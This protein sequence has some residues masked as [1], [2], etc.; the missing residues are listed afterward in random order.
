MSTIAIIGATGFVGTALTLR[1]LD[2]GHHVL[3][4]SR[5]PDRWPLQHKDLKVVKG[6][7]ADGKGL[8]DLL[9]R[10]D[11]AYYL[12]HSLAQDEADF[13]WHETN[14]AVQFASAANRVGLRK[15]IY[16]GGLGPEGESSHHLRSRQLVGK[17]LGLQHG[18]CV[19]FR[20]SIVLGANSTSFEM[21]KA[22][23]QRLPV[24]PYAPWLET[25]CQPIGLEDL[26]TYLVG[27]LDLQG[28]GHT[29]VEIGGPR[30][31]PY[32]ELLDLYAKLDGQT[33]PKFL[34][35]KTDQR[36]LF[37]LL[38]LLIPEYA[39]V[40][41]KLFLS[42]EFPSVVTDRSAEELFPDVVPLPLEEALKRAHE[43][44][45]T[46]YPAVWEGDFWKELKDQTLLQTRQGQQLLVDK[47]KALAASRP[48]EALVHPFS[49]M[50]QLRDKLKS[51]LPG[52]RGGP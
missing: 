48:T 43:A 9:K 27:A 25:L 41:K 39:D 1:L 46:H 34:L 5:H 40:G 32:G 50:H 20:A 11:V 2:L 10:A 30:A 7:L 49:A 42:L 26:L 8:D 38:D 24:R 33:R 23:H 51:R 22:I 37:P 44:S 14:A 4:L 29:V 15:T 17:I 52:R 13:E 35:P 47:L 3:A 31:V 19:E 21:L 36:V 6:D 16:L 18:A 12:A 45:K 28:A